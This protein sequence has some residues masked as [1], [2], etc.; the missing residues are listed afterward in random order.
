M[1]HWPAG[2]ESRSGYIREP[3]HVIDIM[4]TVLD[5]AEASYPGA[6]KQPGIPPLDGV[7]LVPAFHGQPLT[8]SKPLFFQFNKGSAVRDGRWKHVRNSPTWE[9]YDLATDRTETRDLA[10]EQPDVV[11]RMDA[12]WLAR[13]EECTGCEWTGMLSRDGAGNDD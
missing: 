6:S 5:V 9:H 8:R 10:S 11:S 3:A 2:I 7:S 12:A 1:A 4:P 13:W